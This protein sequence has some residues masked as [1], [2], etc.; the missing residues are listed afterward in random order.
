MP[1]ETIVIAAG[2]LRALASHDRGQRAGLLERVLSRGELR[3]MPELGPTAPLCRWQAMLLEAVD[4]ALDAADY[5][6]GPV[7]WFGARGEPAP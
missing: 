6:S 4:P 3:A 2:F 7:S 1:D 5:A